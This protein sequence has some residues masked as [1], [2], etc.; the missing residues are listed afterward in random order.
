MDFRRPATFCLLTLA[1][2]AGCRQNNAHR[3]LLER[4]LRFQEDRIYEL[5]AELETAHRELNKYCNTPFGSGTLREPD[6]STFD[7]K[8]I[9]PSSPTIETPSLDRFAPPPVQPHAPP[10]VELPPPVSSSHSNAAPPF[11][12]P[13]VSLP[14]SVDS[15]EGF[16]SRGVTPGASAGAPPEVILPD[17]NTSSTVERPIPQLKPMSSPKFV[18]PSMKPRLDEESAPRS[19]T[20]LPVS[21]SVADDVVKSLVLSRRTGGLNLDDR[22]GDDGVLV[23]IEPRNSRG[24]T[25]PIVGDLSLVLIDPAIAGEGGRYAR[26]DF[27]AADAAAL[28]RTENAN[29]PAGLYLELPWPEVPPQHSRLKLFVRMKADDDRQLQLDRDLNVNLGSASSS[30]MKF[31]PQRSSPTL[32]PTIVPVAAPGQSEPPQPTPT[33][34]V[35]GQ[36]REPIGPTP[37]APPAAMPEPG[38]LPDPPLPQADPLSQPIPLAEPTLGPALIPAGSR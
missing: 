22:P 30:S 4:E 35:W 11:A 7:V 25:V 27:T 23:V 34:L 6:N 28:F 36:G 32:A 12:G 8:P 3:E 31:E 18:S 24:E 19:T 9:K 37:A 15:P 2:S 10:A 13:P 5:E 29:D 1:L 38:R 26:W 16:P 20:S 33:R 17:V 14:P 21:R